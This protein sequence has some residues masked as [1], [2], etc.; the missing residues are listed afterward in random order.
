MTNELKQKNDQPN[1]EQAGNKKPSNRLIYSVIAGLVL[2]VAGI[3]AFLFVSRDKFSGGNIPYIF[4]AISALLILGVIIA[5]VAIKKKGK[6]E[7]DYRTF[8]IMGIIWLPLGIATDN[9]S[10]WAMGLIFIAIG[11]ANK[12][13]WRKQTWHDLTPGEKNFKIW[14]M[15]ILGILVL[16]GLAAYILVQKKTL[17]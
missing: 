4:I 14:I 7:P 8:F 15:A 2:F 13:K 16:A 17:F 3:V 10:F 5:I 11:L 1:S 12:S 9:P 6:H